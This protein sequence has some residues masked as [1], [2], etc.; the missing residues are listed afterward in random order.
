VD[1]WWANCV[2]GGETR[3][4]LA[5]SSCVLERARHMTTRGTGGGHGV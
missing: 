2:A 4:F 5:G 3:R 1:E